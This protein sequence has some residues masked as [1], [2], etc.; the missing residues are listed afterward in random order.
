MTVSIRTPPAEKNTNMLLEVFIEIKPEMQ[1]EPDRALIR[2]STATHMF[3]AHDED[4]R[5]GELPNF[6]ASRL[7]NMTETCEMTETEIQI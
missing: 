3:M 2:N 1:K 7:Q 5:T 6:D 4:N